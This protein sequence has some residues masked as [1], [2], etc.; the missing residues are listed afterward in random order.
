MNALTSAAQALADDGYLLLPA[1]AEPHSHLDKAFL[2]ER[3]ENRTGDLMGAILAMEAA[4]DSI[5][6]SERAPIASKPGVSRT[7]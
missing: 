3:V 2:A 7:R 4:R 6:V 1:F 5:T